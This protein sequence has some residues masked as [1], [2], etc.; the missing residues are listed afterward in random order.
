MKQKPCNESLGSDALKII[1][2]DSKGYGKI[3]KLAM[4]DTSLSLVA[5]ALLAYLCSYAGKGTTAFPRREKILRDMGINK[6]TFCKHMKSLEEARYITRH[7]T[8]SGTVYELATSIPN[9]NGAMIDLKSSGYGTVPKLV[10]LDAGLSVKAKGLYAYICSFAGAGKSAWPKVGT[11]LRDL[12]IS[13]NSFHKYQKEL[14]DAGYMTSEQKVEEGRY[15]VNVYTL[16]DIVSVDNSGENRVEKRKNA[17][18]T[19]TAMS[20]EVISEN[21]APQFFGR[22]YI[23]NNST[24]NNYLSI[25]KSYKEKKHFAHAG[26]REGCFVENLADKEKREKETIGTTY[27][28]SQVRELIDSLSIFSECVAWAQAKE[29]LGHFPA[30]DGKEKF[31]AYSEI[32]VDELVNQVYLFFKRRGKRVL[33]NRTLYELNDLRAWFLKYVYVESLAELCVDTADKGCEIRDLKR[34]FKTCVINLAIRG[35]ADSQRVASGF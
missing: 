11:I 33:V 29:G 34:Y 25:D 9:T 14:V 21:T 20:E 1:G 5:K 30:E 13:S 23:N 3:H 12:N 31:I 27:S 26:A 8:G 10:M 19:Q 15:G 7:K 22:P 32:V 28:R 4:R 18:T 6:D 16:N 2:V 35:Y 17:T 24:N